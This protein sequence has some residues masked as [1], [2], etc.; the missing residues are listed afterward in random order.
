MEMRQTVGWIIVAEVEMGGARAFARRTSL[1]RRR[2]SIALAISECV[3]RCS[4]PA[5]STTRGVPLEPPS[6]ELLPI[7][8]VVRSKRANHIGSAACVEAILPP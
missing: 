2:P 8:D 3:H 1:L 5:F 4:C 7:V 6:S